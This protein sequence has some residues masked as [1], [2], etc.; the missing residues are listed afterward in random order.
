MDTL[1]INALEIPVINILNVRVPDIQH[2]EKP[3]HLGLYSVDA[4]VKGLFA[5]VITEFTIHNDNRRV[6][7]G[8][9]EF[10]LPDGGVVCGY[11]ID[12]NGIMTDASVVE[13]EKARIA[14]EN[15]VKKGVDPGLVE[16]VRGN[17]Y[18][19]RIYPIP[20]NGSRRIRIEYMTPLVIGTNGDAA[21]SLP[22]PSEKLEHR[23]VVISVDLPEA[24]APVIGGLGD[25]RFTQ[26]EAVWRVE[27]H[28]DDIKPDDN[29]L[30]GIPALP[31]ILTSV[32]SFR[33]DT[34]FAVCVRNRQ[35]DKSESIEMPSKWRIIWDASGSRTEF[36]KK[37]AFSLIEKLPDSAEYELHV[38]RN[39]LEP[40]RKFS[41]R[42]ELLKVL[43]S[44][45]HDG[46]TDFS[47]L[48]E[49]A[50]EK[51]DGMTLMFSDGLDTFERALPEFGV[52][53]AAIVSGKN[54][55]IASLRRICGGNVV[56]L[57]IIS[58]DD[59]FAQI[60]HP[61]PVIASVEG[62][63]ISNIQGIG[64][65]ALGRVSVI[66]RLNAETADVKIALSDGQIFS[67]KLAKNMAKE[68]NTLA[69]AWAARRIDEL[70]PVADDY[71]EELLAVGRRFSIVSPVSSMIVFERLEQWLE[72]DIEPPE[73]L[74]E[75]HEQWVKRRK[76]KAY[77]LEKETSIWKN[78]L[79]DEWDKRVSWW[80]SPM[81]IVQK[82]KSGLF[83][84]AEGAAVG[85]PNPMA[86]AGAPGGPVQRAMQAVSNGFGAVSQAVS[87]VMGLGAA[88]FSGGNPAGTGASSP[89]GAPAMSAPRS[90]MMMHREPECCVEECVES[91][92][93]PADNANGTDET[94]PNANASVSIQAWDPKMPY[95]DAI[96]D[97]E[98][99]FGSKDECYPE[100]LR[101]R[102][103]YAS[104]PAFYLDCAGLFFKL[105]MQEL[106]IR[107][108]SNLVELKI[109]D[110]ALLRVFAW[111]LRE[112]GELDVSIDVL[113]K[114]L[115]MREDEVVSWR[116]LAL[117]LAMRAK[118]N[119]CADD[120]QEALE[121]FKKAA[122]SS[123]KRGDAIWTSLVAVEEFNA[124]ASW[125]EAQKW[126]DKVPE[127][128]EIDSKYRK[129]LDLDLRIVLMWDSD[130][131][132]IDLHV[133]E[134]SGEEVFYRNQ[135]SKTG[136]LLSHDVTT[137]YGP[138]E[139]MHKNAPAG[140]YQIMSNYF[141]SHQQKLTGNVTVTATIFTNWGRSNEARQMMS[142]RLENAKDH[143]KIGSIDVT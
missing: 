125:C 21:L 30:I 101:Q 111:R 49:L 8:E 35:M 36:D 113:R 85:A 40:V 81:P 22:M 130:N 11:A 75:I 16:Q 2:N 48:K 92:S 121:L 139:Y 124:L 73:S 47:P 80:N 142:L 78:R 143:C 29:L 44:I 132:D 140:T 14:F 72:Y 43:E 52:H 23:D 77:S 114:V 91:C 108:L 1:R 9:L 93:E 84:G 61:S 134:P 126:A 102:Q 66:G 119:H 71:R 96:K 123:W 53:S 24:S 89:M 105:D 95:L 58:I 50:Q 65:Q 133:L 106:G 120:A 13:K 54:R 59:A 18:R 70:S 137:G 5:R 83:D 109:D 76:Q 60:L 122:F 87:N 88:R 12:I 138:E 67:M 45:S 17:A 107:I 118:K 15:E 128:P 99:V 141:A 37:Q 20:A 79:S 68:G 32:E 6:F 135:R 46:G 127:I 86:M 3:L 116:D 117:T 110:P 63:G 31:D 74:K 33:G 62:E 131:T 97:A 41:L 90:A 136:A 26:A 103:K 51:F 55:D 34:F 7:E 56:D 25:R 39:A 10:P 28:E 42:S 115:K 94:A 82:P 129:L 57:N 112:A 4:R 104:S 27:S 69:A 19:T 98:K 38:F 100:Y 64:F